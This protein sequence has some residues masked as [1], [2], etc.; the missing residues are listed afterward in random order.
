[1]RRVM[2]DELRVLDRSGKHSQPSYF[3]THNSCLFVPEARP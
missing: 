1:M 3:I 2:S